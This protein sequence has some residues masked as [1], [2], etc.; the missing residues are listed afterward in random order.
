MQRGLGQRRQ[1]ADHGHLNS[2]VGD[3]PVLALEGVEGVIVEADDESAKHV[4]PGG[5]DLTNGGEE[6]QAGVLGF[7]DLLQTLRVGRFDAE[8]HPGKIRLAEQSQ[9]FLVLRQVQRGLG[10]ELESIAVRAL[11]IDQKPQQFLGAG[12]V[13]DQVVV[14]KKHVVHIER[15]QAVEF[16]PDLRHV[17]DARLTAE[18]HND[19]AEVTLK[20]ATAGVLQAHGRVFVDLK[21]I[22]ARRRGILKGNHPGLAVKLAGRPLFKVAAEPRP[23][24]FGLAGHHGV[25][26]VFV[27]LGAQRRVAAARHHVVAFSAVVIQ[28]LPLARKL[29]G[30]A[31]DTDEI[32]LGRKWYG[33]D[34]F[35]DDFHFP[36]RRAQRGQRRQ[37]EGRVHGPF[38]PQN[39]FHGPA[40][41]PETFRKPGVDQNQTDGTVY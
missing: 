25:R 30:H 33:L 32:R 38:A 4:D 36:V 29:D 9:Q 2:G 14:H 21:E 20:R 15:A 1:Q 23:D 34:V 7:V 13:A 10:P 35:V 11:V 40:E 5:I 41:A 6:V 28:Q 3:E 31:A 16:L 24:I 27:V 12:L 17:L 8:K 18:H 39:L 26:Q 19:V 37:P 22:K